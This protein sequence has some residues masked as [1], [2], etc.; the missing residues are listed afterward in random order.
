MQS[1]LLR[2]D[3]FINEGRNYSKQDEGV[4]EE[5]PNAGKILPVEV[6]LRD[7]S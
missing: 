7:T 1:E 3:K 4:P 2:D 6:T 5:K